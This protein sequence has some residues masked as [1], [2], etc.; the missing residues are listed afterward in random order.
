MFKAFR[1]PKPEGRFKLAN[2]IKEPVR[3]VA[4]SFIV[5]PAVA[6]AAIM[7]AAPQDG[8][9]KPAIAVL[10]LQITILYPII[11]GACFAGWFYLARAG[12]EK[13]GLLAL[14]VPLTIMALWAAAFAVF[15]VRFLASVI[16][17][18]VHLGGLS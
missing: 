6:I 18:W 16:G 9:E 1:R 12:R 2:P 10:F 17:H 13:V 14:L 11:A 8:V 7:Y 15:A 4:Q 3:A 5:W